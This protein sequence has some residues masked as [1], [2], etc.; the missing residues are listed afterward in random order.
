MKRYTE[1]LEDSSRAKEIDSKFVNGYNGKGILKYR[2]ILGSL[3]LACKK[4]SYASRKFKEAIKLKPDD[5]LFFNKFRKK[6]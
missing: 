1:A 6:Y 3:Y 2:Y 5:L 4:L